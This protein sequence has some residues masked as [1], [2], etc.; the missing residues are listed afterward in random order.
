MTNNFYVYINILEELLES[1]QY[2]FNH[3]D[4]MICFTLKG[5]GNK[6]FSLMDRG[7]GINMC[8]LKNKIHCEKS[9]AFEGIGEKMID[10]SIFS[11]VGNHKTHV[12]DLL[13]KFF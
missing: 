12:G 4:V 1:G 10:G 13:G 5:A 2:Q 8:T 9:Q 6:L 11:R 3:H 7:F